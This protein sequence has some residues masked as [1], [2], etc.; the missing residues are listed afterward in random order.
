MQV[1]KKVLLAASSLPAV[2]YGLGIGSL[3]TAAVISLK[4]IK[5]LM[6][7]LKV[8]KHKL[9]YLDLEDAACIAYVIIIFLLLLR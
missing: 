6:K 4:L 8:I 5:S 3:V 7:V 2:F 9:F 1:G